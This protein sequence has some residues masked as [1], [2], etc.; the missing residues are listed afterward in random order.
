MNVYTV[1]Q[2]FSAPQVGVRLIPGDTVGK[3][4][5]RLSVLIG[6][7]EYENHAFWDWV[8]SV[9]S[10]NYL[11]FTGTLPDPGTGAGNVKGG[12]QAISSGD[13]SVTVSGAAWGFVPSGIAVVVTKPAGGDSLF[14]TVRMATLTADGFT[15]DLSSSAASAGYSLCYVVIE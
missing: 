2:E 12:S 7:T 3:I 4:A 15:A 1:T 5:A 13:D 6:G 8:G 14:A 11:M 10:L 9:D